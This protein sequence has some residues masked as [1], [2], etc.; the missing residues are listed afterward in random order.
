MCQVLS[1]VRSSSHL[2]ARRPYLLCAHN[3]G[4]I[5]G[6]H[7]AAYFVHLSMEFTATLSHYPFQLP[8]RFHPIFDL[9]MTRF[10]FHFTGMFSDVLLSSL[11]HVSILSTP[12]LLSASNEELPS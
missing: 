10:L 3:D 11:S 8:V 1:T 9:Q 4:I 6:F 2:A 5:E 12:L 7:S